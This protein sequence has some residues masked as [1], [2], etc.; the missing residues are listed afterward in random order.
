MAIDPVIELAR[1]KKGATIERHT[2]EVTRQELP[3]EVQELLLEMADTIRK[4]ETKIFELEKTV[5]A[6]GAVTLHDLLK[7]TA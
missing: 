2:K 7:K 4:H 5:G 6:F 3:P 1:R